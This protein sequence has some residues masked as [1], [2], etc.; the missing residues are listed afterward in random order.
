MKI[1]LIAAVSDD[2]FISR[3]KGVPWDL[4]AD[5]EHFRAYTAG[6]HLL[7]GRATYEEMTGWFTKH[8]PY[9]LSRNPDFRPTVGRRV[10]SVQIALINAAGET[11]ELVV[12]GGAQAYALALPYATTLVLTRVHDRLGGGLAFPALSAQEWVET[13]RQ[14][15]PADARHAFAM[16]FVTLERVRVGSP[17]A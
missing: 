15:H 6:K 2:G 9:V 4:P 17:G 14:E 5:R 3:G 7:L 8:T 11:D 13:S 1:T 12:C 10:P 16:T